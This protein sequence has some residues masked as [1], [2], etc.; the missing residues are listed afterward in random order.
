M[1]TPSNF[2]FLR[3]AFPQLYAHAAQ[4]ERL[5]FAAPRA[6][7]FYARFALEQAVLWLYEND[8][9]LILPYENSLGAL[10]HEPTFQQALKPGL[11]P[12]IRLIQ[13]LGNKAVHQ[14]NDVS[15]QDAL[16]LVQELFHILYWLC[17]SYSRPGQLRGQQLPDLVFDR[18]QI[19]CPVAPEEQALS[20]KQLEEL[21]EQLSETDALRRI[22]AERRQKTE[23]ELEALRAEIATIRQANAA[24]EDTHDYNEADTRRLLID[25]LLR[26][27]GWDA[28]LP[29]ATEVEVQGMP[30]QKAGDTGRGFVDYV[31]W[32]SDGK[33]LALVEAKRTSKSSANGQHQAKLYAD[34]LQRQYGQRP[35]I[36]YSNGYETGLWDDLNYPPRAVLGF[37]KKAELERMIFRRSNKKRL[38]MTPINED[39]AGRDRPYQ[40]EAIRRITETFEEQLT[41][42]SLLVM[43]T[44][45]G[46][47]RTAIALVDLMKRSNW[48]QR[49]LFLA[50]RNA[51]LTQAYRAFQSQLPTVTPV[52][53][54][55]TKDVEGANVVMSTYKTMLNAINRLSS[56]ER[57]FGVG[58]FDLVI[59]DE[60][61][62]SI[63]KKY[64]EIFDYFDALLV[65][66][67]ATPRTEV[68]RD[69]YRIFEL[70]QGVPTFAYELDDAVKDGHLVPPKGV[71]VPFKFLRTGVK[72]S[73]LSRE[74][75]LEYE[76][77]FRD[78]DTG[79]LP[80]EI[81]A[82]ELNRWLFNID[83]VD[84]ALELLM[85]RGLKVNSGDRLGKTIIFAR[86]HH[87][88]E[89][90]AQRFNANYP[91][92]KGH[93]AKV[94][95]SYDNYA[96]S[97]L[98][99]FSDPN[100]EPNIAI[101][102][103]MLDTG[104]DVPEAV[105]LVFFKPVFSPVKFNQ[106]I[107][108]GTRPCKDL[109]GPGQDKTEFLVFDLCGNFEYFEQSIA[110]TD[111]KPPETLTTRL[112][113][114]RLELA[115]LMRQQEGNDA[116]EQQHLRSA[117]L[118]EL[119]RHVDTMPRDN[120]V[121]RRRL[122]QVE[123]FAD[124]ERWNE[125]NDDDVAVIAESLASLPN[126]LP[127]EDP[128]AKEFDLL[129]LK[130]Q[131]AILKASTSYERL[132]D[133]VRDILNQLETKPDVPMIN[134][135]LAFIQEAQ[136]EVWWHDV[137]LPMVDDI[138]VR[139]RDLV[140]FIDRTKREIVIT[141]FA[142][143][144]GEVQD[145]TVPTYQTG[146]SPY[147]YRKKV[148]AY[149]R[150][151]EDH[152][153]IAKLKRNI[154]LTEADLTALEEMLF[155]AEEI[156]SRQRFEEVYGKTKSLKR[157]IREIV[158]L[159]RNA[160]KQ[161]FAHYLE[162]ST[163]SAN[164]IRFVETIIDY[165]TQ[166]G[167]MDP[168]M[169]YEPPFTDSHPE[170]LDGVFNDDEADNLVAIIR[171]FNETIDV[172]YGVA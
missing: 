148:E 42:K 35:V 44:G 66:L 99:D 106:M 167:I 141:D 39:I 149:I 30:I 15:E 82:A 112:V 102:V 38:S 172:R 11:F 90:I 79:E 60:A 138:R 72:Y 67:T 119:H 75:Q 74:E 21:E 37:L 87:H 163:M 129:C 153:T 121:V 40:R 24:A 100:K 168:G 4:A 144:M 164:Q 51:L 152:I 93:F 135:Q 123:T 91:Q 88:A 26:E 104:V 103:D 155:T 17:R 9:N 2:A 111:Q 70:Q 12:K 73:E 6:S 14:S 98:D 59:V 162:G 23:A 105:N 69:T 18:A 150:A 146:F 126:G 166:N 92:Y 20:K 48:V 68:D 45:T 32:G 159:D 151:H 76:E 65:G 116:P 134:A 52:D 157:L 140:K 19:P 41:R 28:A 85:E 109:F 34:C 3:P 83:T 94:I 122:Q 58:H 130:L 133:R 54:T 107:G 56:D 139:I 96:Q 29:N 143:E 137:T 113:K 47:T 132:R 71:T 13:K 1:T 120:F 114:H 57:L 125:L 142:D 171:T 110:E 169:L 124:R 10:I 5:I 22:E 50:D 165:L 136:E 131:L 43:A 36:F 118:D 156:E 49:V 170:G 147:Q 61:H 115:Q 128:L 77:K 97:L 108:R 145:V 101:S 55:R 27:A 78:E 33:P 127:N 31:L 63:Y 81:D 80:S 16:R 86:N 89:F 7:C 160:A 158:G 62:R 64:G 25:V 46:K 8:P 117:L 161:A 84:Q 154:P 95:D 53:L